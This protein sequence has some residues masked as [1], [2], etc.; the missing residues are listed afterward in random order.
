MMQRYDI[1]GYSPQEIADKLVDV[2]NQHCTKQGP[3]IPKDNY[4]KLEYARACGSR[5][6]RHNAN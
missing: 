6:P 3:S 1:E 2:F 5:I 4:E